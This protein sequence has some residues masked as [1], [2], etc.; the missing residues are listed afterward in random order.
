MNKK[1]LALLALILFP[2]VFNSCCKQDCDQPVASVD[3]K[4]SGF[5][6]GKTD[7]LTVYYFRGGAQTEER[8]ERYTTAE[9]FLYHLPVSM[10]YYYVL[11]MKDMQRSDTLRI[12]NWREHKCKN[13]CGNNA[14]YFMPVSCSLNGWPI[15]GTNIEITK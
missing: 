9:Q 14:V 5:D 11:Q 1:Q 13:L 4:Y 3:I 10:D 2:I 7:S 12:T 6:A 15:N 8:L